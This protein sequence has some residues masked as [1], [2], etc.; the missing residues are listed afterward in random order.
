MTQIKKLLSRFR[1]N[2]SGASAVEF[3]IVAT[4]FVI[5]S[6]GVMELGRTYQV[7]NELAYAADIGARELSLLVNNPNVSPANYSSMVE[8]EINSTFQ[9]YAGSN[10]TVTVT[11]NTSLTTGI[12]YQE[13]KLAYPMSVFIPFRTGTYN[14]EV[15]RRAVQ[16]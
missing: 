11:Q 2:D 12:T 6:M 4:I 9:G 1:R 14:L 10:L 15:T 8:A 3:S 5:A 7:R 16:L 13:L